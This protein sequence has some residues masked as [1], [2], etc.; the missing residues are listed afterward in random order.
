LDGEKAAALAL[1]ATLEEE[2]AA[3]LA[4]IAQRD[5]E[6]AAAAALIETFRAV[7]AED[8]A[9]IAALEAERETDRR[10]L[11]EREADLEK[12][13][14]E[15]AERLSAFEK[16][17]AEQALALATI[18]KLEEERSSTNKSA[19]EL[20]AERAR[21]Q[22]EGATALARAEQFQIDLKAALDRA[23]QL[24]AQL[25]EAE[26][27]RLADVAAAA[28]LRERLANSETELDA[29][30]LALE[31]A[32]AE[33]EQTLTL[34]AAAEAARK[35]LTEQ[36]LS[37]TEGIDREAALR[38]VAE[39]KLAEAEA[40][41]LAEQRKV[42]A[43]NAQVRELN[44][45]LGTLQTLLDEAAE[46]DEQA[47]VQIAELGGKL[48]QALAQKVSELSRFRSEFFGRMRDLLG[49]R[50]DVRVVGDRFVLQSEVLF[51]SASATLGPAGRV[52]LSKLANVVRELAASAPPDLNWILR[53]DGH[54]DPIP[55]S[56]TRRYR[57]NWELSQARALSV[58]R[59]MSGSLGISPARL[60]ANGFGEYQPINP[61]D[62]PEARAQNRRIELKLTEK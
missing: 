34:L 15:N 60:A 18:A 62:T 43:L 11:A 14:A 24:A 45:Q 61:A 21:L 26:E 19:N 39:G 25:T 57:D 53:V 51:D 5:T 40:Q 44:T 54:T 41:T 30:A 20:E 36:A 28:A 3:A 1:I 12:L 22:V 8:D 55:L 4:D 16:L 2:K 35:E 58:V 56:G 38:R 52:E 48:N 46:R 42:S 7:Q 32:R 27:A 29:M 59:Y 23:A 33:A 49:G 13:S 50:D 10:T 6:Q 9:T 31:E 47:Q 17:S 37:G